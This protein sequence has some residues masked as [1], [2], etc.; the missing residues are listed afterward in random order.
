MHVLDLPG[1][2]TD[3]SMLMLA[4]LTIGGRC[5]HEDG[6]GGACIAGC[7][8]EWMMAVMLVV[9]TM[10]MIV[11]WVVIV[12]LFCLPTER[13][14]LH[15]YAARLVIGA[16]GFQLTLKN[17]PEK[18]LPAMLRQPRKPLSTKLSHQT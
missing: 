3:V 12:F 13:F 18:S 8:C 2:L 9:V 1:A 10:A 17:F 7:G 4:V 5:G 6:D 15:G 16:S 11:M 14:E